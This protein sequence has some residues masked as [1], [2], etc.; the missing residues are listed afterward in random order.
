MSVFVQ[1]AEQGSLTAA[2]NV[3]GLSLPSVVRILASLEQSVQVRLFNRTTRRVT[4]TQEGGF[5][6]EQCRKILADI[7]ETERALG[8]D[9]A[10]P[11]GKITLTAP[12]RFG[13]MHVAPAVASFLKQY[14]NTRVD[15]RLVDR[16]IDL[17]EEGIDVAVRIAH[18]ADSSLIAKRMGAIRQVVCASPALLNEVGEPSHPEALTGLPCICFT[19]VSQTS[20]WHFQDNGKHLSVPVTGKLVCNQ[21][22]ASVEAC[23]AGTGFGLFYCYQVMPYIHEGQLATVLTDFEL[24]PVPLSLVYPHARLLSARVRVMVDWLSDNV[25]W[26]LTPG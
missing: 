22:R 10:E 21:V 7:E 3:L 8:Q 20:A 14:P 16:V 17:L 26:P 18:L 23:V 11:A 19:G 6:L 2:A 1:I 12:V 13:E 4:L 5:Y 24:D 9:Q 25:G 15:L